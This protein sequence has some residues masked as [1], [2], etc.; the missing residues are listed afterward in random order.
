MDREYELIQM[1]ARACIEGLYRYAG[2][3]AAENH[4]D[5]LPQLKSMVEQIHTWYGLGPDLK[6]AAEAA[7]LACMAPIER[8]MRGETL[9]LG[10]F[11]EAHQAA[12]ANC[13][14]VYQA[15]LQAEDE[16]VYDPDIRL[17]DELIRETAEYLSTV[18]AG[19]LSP[20]QTI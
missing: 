11:T 19:L 20:T 12:I 2:L 9:S 18:N 4:M 1:Q 13:L 16:P 15:E 8:L 14:S 10:E 7:R 3:L 17:C 5:R 6:P